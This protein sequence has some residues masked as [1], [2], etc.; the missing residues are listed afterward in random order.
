MGVPSCCS[1]RHNIN[2]KGLDMEKEFQ[3][4]MVMKTTDGISEKRFGIINRVVVCVCTFFLFILCMKETL[5]YDEAY[6]IGMINRSYWDIIKITANDVHTPFYYFLLKFFC[7]IFGPWKIYAAK[8]FSLIFFVLHLVIGGRMCRKLYGRKVEFYWLLLTGFMP[9]MVIHST[10]ARMYTLGLFLFTVT[11]YFAYSLYKEESVRKWCL[12]T[13]ASVM[14]MYVH[15]YSMLEVFVLY[16]IIAGI[17]LKNKRYRS[18]KAYCISGVVAG[19]CYLPWLLVVMRQMGARSGAGTLAKLTYYGVDVYFAEW[20]SHSINPRPLEILFSVALFI[21]V[22]YY[23]RKYVDET[24]DYIPYAGMG[25]AAVIVTGAVTLSA[26]VV[27]SFSGRYIFPVFGLIWLFVAVG[28]EKIEASWK[29]GIIIVLILLCAAFTYKEEVRLEKDAGV[30]Q[31]LAF[32]E[33]N[34]GEDDIIMADIYTDALIS[35]YIPEAKYMIYGYMPSYIPFDNME[36]FYDWDQLEGVDTVWYVERTPGK[37]AQLGD[38]F[39]TEIV[40][41][42]SFSHYDFYL[43]KAT[44]R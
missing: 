11:A 36:A 39:D 14:T 4:K 5:G 20:F 42:F 1:F 8:I 21:Y 32:M 3:N 40:L 24:K 25:I 33:E 37:A 2:G 15:T 18:M 27:N 41:E 30:K 31:Y 13:A 26:T 16:L 35:V 17:F 19:L 34:L 38:Y 6:T 28:I 22:S 10:W 23:V 29:K 12:F 9:L 44:R 43:E 7:D